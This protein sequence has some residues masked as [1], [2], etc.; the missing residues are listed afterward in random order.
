MYLHS[1]RPGWRRS[2]AE[3]SLRRLPHDVGRRP[4]LGL[5]EALHLGAVVRGRRERA[6]A[7]SAPLTRRR[8]SLRRGWRRPYAQASRRRVFGT[9]EHKDSLGWTS[10][11]VTASP[12]QKRTLSRRQGEQRRRADRP[13][14]F[15][16]HSS[17][18]PLTGT[19]P[20]Q[21]PTSIFMSM[22]VLISPLR[23]RRRHQ[24]NGRAVGR[25]RGH[26]G[27]I[28]REHAVGRP[29]GTASLWR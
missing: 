1:R 13:P 14:V 3:A 12:P 27:D 18:L 21:R 9:C 4:R 25:H 28:L 29:R 16:S 6:R 15:P 23:V 11:A 26:A 17:R 19:R 24:Q 8:S 7:R 10:R 2:S 5:E 20:G 22:S